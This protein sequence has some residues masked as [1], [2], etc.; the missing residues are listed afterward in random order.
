MAKGMGSGRR[1]LVV[2]DNVLL[3]ELITSLV[4]SLGFE[5]R[6]ATSV[7]EALERLD[8]FKPD[9][10]L[11]DL[12]LGAGP[13][14]L[15]L[16]A[17]IEKTAPNVAAVILSAH[18]SPQLVSEGPWPSARKTPYLVKQDITSS[19]IIGTALKAALDGKP[20]DNPTEATAPVVQVTPAQAEVLRLMA[21]GMSNKQIADYR[22]STMRAVEQLVHRTFAALGLSTH[23]N[24]NPR[25]EAVRKYRDSE[26]IVRAHQTH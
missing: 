16:L 17:A 23:D 22:G 10:A 7:T 14:G 21:A 2:E 4:E 18:R 3:A 12:D 8:D 11:V 5:T 24:L 9:V 13:T 15:D 20:F 26:V 19:K 6:R 25:V 1:A